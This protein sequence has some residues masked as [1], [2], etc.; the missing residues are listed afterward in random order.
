MSEKVPMT[1]EGQARLRE[2]MRRLKEIDLPQVVKD[3]GTAR[4]HGDLSE[5]AEYHAAKERQGMIVARISYLEQ[6]LSRAEVIDPSKLSGSKVQFGAKVKLANVDTDEEQSFQI[7]G[8]E[9]ADLKVGRISIASP[10]ARALLG[11]EVG[12]EVRVNMPAGPR[13]YEILEVSYA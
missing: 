13:T 12:E 11:H 7:V 4:E 6:T 9:E 8:P 2:E 3:I 10:L 1:P 5:N